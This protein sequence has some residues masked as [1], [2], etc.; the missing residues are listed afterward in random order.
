MK[1]NM[2]MELKLYQNVSLAFLVNEIATLHW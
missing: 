1:V 2:K